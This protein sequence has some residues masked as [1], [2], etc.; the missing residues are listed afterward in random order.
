MRLSLLANAALTPIIEPLRALS[1]HG[2]DLHILSDR[3]RD[4]RRQLR[5]AAETAFHCDALLLLD[6]YDLLPESG[7]HNGAVPLIVP[8]VHNAAALLLG[9]DDEYRRLYRLYDGGLSWFI[10]GALRE[11]SPG[12]REDCQALCAL[13]GTQ[14][15]L[16][17][18]TLAARAVSQ[19]NGWDYLE[20]SCDLTLLES[21]LGGQWPVRDAVVFS[22]EAFVCAL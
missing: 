7:W 11:Y 4:A 16:P 1:P 3:P 2:T 22:P 20:Q 10:P 9:G 6:G 14:L 13:T 15:D 19:Y 8:R 21:L 18:S 12:P 5:V 17:D